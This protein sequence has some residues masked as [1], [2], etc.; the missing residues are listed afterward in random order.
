MKYG[1]SF[2]TTKIGKKLQGDYPD[3]ISRHERELNFVAGKLGDKDVM[4]LER[5]ATALYIALN[6]ES[7]QSARM[8]ALRLR[9]L[10]KHVSVKDSN[11][12]VAEVDQIRSEWAELQSANA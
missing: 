6:D 2:V 12:A 1:P 11:E 7:N 3:G 10:K 4:E 5:M 9:Q 8:R